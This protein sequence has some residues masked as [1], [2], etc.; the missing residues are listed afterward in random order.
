M[1]RT[2]TVHVAASDLRDLLTA[3]LPHAA[4]DGLPILNTIHLQG[5][6]EW[7]TATATDRHT[8]GIARAKLPAPVGLTAAL[9]VSSA[10]AVLAAFKPTRTSDPELALGFGPETLTV[11]THGLAVCIDAR[12]TYQLTPGRYPDLFTLAHNPAEPAE[13]AGVHVN[14]SFMAR[15]AAAQREGEPMRIIPA[16]LGRPVTVT[17]GDRFY[18]AIMPVNYPGDESPA[19]LHA[20]W[21]ALFPPAPK[22][23]TS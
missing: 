20:Q 23:K 10:R 17:V 6:G 22:K 19:A 1:T 7:L 4:R 8:F 12:I 18:G 2:T 5:H 9:P 15:F 3:V 13:W 11:E 14:P 21:A 16:G